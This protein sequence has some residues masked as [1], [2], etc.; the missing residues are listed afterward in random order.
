MSS[1]QAN[2]LGIEKFV[3]GFLATNCYLAYDKET[4]QGILIDP[5]EYDAG[6]TDFANSNNIDI[7]FI[8]NTHGHADH[9][10]GN[11]KFAFPIM[12]HELDE[13]CLHDSAKNLSA[14]AG[15]DFKSTR[16]EKLLTD[17]DVV[18]LGSL[19]FKIIHT[20]GHSPGG[21]SIKCGDVLFSGD[22]LFFEGIGR[23][24]LP[25]GDY[26]AIVSSIKDKLFTLD[27]NVKVFPGHG[28]ETTIGHEKKCNPFL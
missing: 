19:E 6:I 7:R 5:G 11:S 25:G 10:K 2:N 3:V 13:P 18:E 23:T 9:I 27:D 17:G 1:V 15:F 26:D 16:A 21:I 12:I 14:A 4:R 22:T 24:D 28:P 8:L 20:P